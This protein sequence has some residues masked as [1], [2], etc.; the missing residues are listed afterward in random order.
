MLFNFFLIMIFVQKKLQK[1]CQV[2]N[3]ADI[4]YYYRLL[5]PY[6]IISITGMKPNTY[7]PKRHL[8]AV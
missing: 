4:Y 1:Y 8:T 6:I 3:T 5:S 2:T 7:N